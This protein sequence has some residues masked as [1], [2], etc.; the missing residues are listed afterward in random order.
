[1]DALNVVYEEKETRGFIKL[2][3]P[4]DR[5]EDAI[6]SRS[7]IFTWPDVEKLSEYSLHLDWGFRPHGKCA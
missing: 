4:S 6:C 1:M 2:N 5:G 7:V 3:K